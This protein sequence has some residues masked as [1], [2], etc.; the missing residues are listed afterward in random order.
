MMSSYAH[1]D[2]WPDFPKTFSTTQ[3]SR[4]V[5]T[6]PIYRYST[7]HPPRRCIFPVWFTSA[8]CKIGH[9][10]GL[11]WMLTRSGT[12]ASPLPGLVSA[13]YRKSFAISIQWNVTNEAYNHCYVNSFAAFWQT[14]QTQRDVERDGCTKCERD[15]RL[16]KRAYIFRFWAILEEIFLHMSI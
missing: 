5:P 14:A 8:C 6:Y 4:T 3:T 1:Y 11:I 9:T 7:T 13:Y 2:K 15:R 12:S 10:S 16:C